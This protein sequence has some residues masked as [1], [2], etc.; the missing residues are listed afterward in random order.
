MSLTPAAEP[1]GRDRYLDWYYR[2]HID[3]T[4]ERENSREPPYW[5]KYVFHDNNRDINYSQVTMRNLLQWYLKWHP[6]IM[7]DLHESV[8]F[9]YTFSGQA[10]QNPSLDPILYGELPL[11][12]NFEMS[13]AAKY[14]MPGIWTHAFVDMWSPGYLAFMS[15]NH[16]G[17]VRMYET[18]GN[19]G[20]TTMKRKVEPPEGEGGPG[21]MN[22]TKREWYRPWPPYKEV[23][24][25]LRNNTNYMETAVLSGLELT[26]SFP[27]MVLENFLKKSRNS[28]ESG[29]TEAPF[30][31][32][33]PAGQRD[34]TRV[35]MLVEL[36][37]L[38]GIEVGEAKE[39]VN[40]KE[41]EFAAG[42]YLI[43]RD[44]PYGR[45]AKTLLEKQDFPTRTCAP[46]TTPAGPWVS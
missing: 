25:S 29:K 31:Y 34:P 42:S 37:L 38:Q 36:L 3:E 12:S 14:G 15:S 40:V 30:G 11:F 6:P 28:I 23:E 10:P 4:D 22:A 33:I 1:D 16:N 7:H 32:V 21:R 44:Q 17:M 39:K 27:R 43:K 35:A 18:F 5:G 24:W 13:Q 19:G 41:G 46:T 9:L 20:A 2:Y 8:P 45:L 26:A